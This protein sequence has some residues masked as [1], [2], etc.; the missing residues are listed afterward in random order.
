MTP[1]LWIAA[2]GVLGVA[3]TFVEAIARLGQRALSEL[4]GDLSTVHWVVFVVATIVMT[5]GEGY[6]ALHRRFAPAVVARALELAA[7]E[8]TTWFVLAPLYAISLV[9]APPR[10]IARSALGVAGIVACVVIVRELASP[11]RGIVDGAVA[12]A[13]GWGLVA[14]LARFAS[15]L[16]EVI[17]SRRATPAS[18]RRPREVG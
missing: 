13:L 5:Y 3:A 4:S 1:R 18:V 9:G 15:A 10:V 11:W 17:A 2:W 8:R 7:H 12:V 6:R 16:A 14:L